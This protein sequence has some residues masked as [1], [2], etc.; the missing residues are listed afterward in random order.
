MNLNCHLVDQNIEILNQIAANSTKVEAL[1]ATITSILNE[2]PAGGSIVDSANP[3]QQQEIKVVHKPPF[4]AK[5]PTEHNS[6]HLELA[7]GPNAE[8]NS[9]SVPDP[10]V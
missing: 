1:H 7:S 9:E 10:V 2:M 4:K 5:R 8:G 6:R 3:D